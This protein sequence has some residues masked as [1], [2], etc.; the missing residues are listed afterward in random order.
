MFITSHSGIDIT[1]NESKLLD[2]KI[3]SGIIKCWKQF[4]ITIGP[5]KMAMKRAIPI[6]Q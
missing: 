5:I 1:G 2:S 6:R 4:D 3:R